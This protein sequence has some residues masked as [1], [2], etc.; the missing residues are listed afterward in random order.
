M[1]S[2]FLGMHSGWVQDLAR[3]ASAEPFTEPVTSVEEAERKFA[4]LYHRAIDRSNLRNDEFR[5]MFW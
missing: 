1:P 5:S 4:A 2:Y 3:L